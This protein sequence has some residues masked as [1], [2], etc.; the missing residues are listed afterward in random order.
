MKKVRTHYD[1][2]KI[3]QD[4]PPEIIKA[5]Y[6][7]L[8]QKHHPDRNG[9]TSESQ[10]IMK[11]INRSYDALSDPE[12]RIKHDEWISQQESPE[13]H[14]KTPEK[15][16][17]KVEFPPP[18]SGEVNFNEL[19]K[20]ARSKI[21]VRV[22]G[23]DENQY[24]IKLDDVF[25]SYA[26]ILGLPIWFYFIYTSIS[27][28]RWTSEAAYWHSGITC[29]VWLLLAKNIS[30][31]YSWHSTPLKSW[32][33]ITPLYLMKL[34]LNRISYWPIST[35]AD[36]KGTHK[37]R[38]GSYQNTDISMTLDGKPESFSVNGEQQ[39]Q[40]L[41][42]KLQQYDAEL[43]AAQKSNDSA[44]II[45]NDEFI[46]LREQGIKSEHTTPSST[47]IIYILLFF[48]SFGGLSAA[49]DLNKNR[50][51]KP[52]HSKSVTHYKKFPEIQK[53]A[54]SRPATVANRSAWLTQAS[55]Q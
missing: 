15:N 44:H 23:Y 51:F 31:V 48:I 11:I 50:P 41:L 38:N 4:A 29:V 32:L 53:P 20:V 35:I 2:L 47:F 43:R 7:A 21:K 42:N 54:Y 26:L 16:S 33:I 10:N 13:I 18:I 3:S 5:A 52:T 55:Y 34:H 40:I 25:W 9:S 36:I 8:S 46:T 17:T 49:Y 24:A 1:N 39:Y 6:R 27:D 19:D 37:Y 30:R 14:T 28:Y 45:N 12:S 22:S